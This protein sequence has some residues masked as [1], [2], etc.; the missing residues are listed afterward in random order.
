MAHLVGPFKRSSATA[1]PRHS[2]A[3]SSTGIRYVRFNHTTRKLAPLTTTAPH[4]SPQAGSASE[5][6]AGQRVRIRATRFSGDAKS[7]F[8][9]T[10]RNAYFY[11]VAN[12]KGRGGRGNADTWGILYDGEDDEAVYC[13]YSHLE[14]GS[15]REGTR[16]DCS[17]AIVILATCR[18]QCRRPPRD[19]PPLSVLYASP[20]RP[21]LLRRP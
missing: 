4:C 20:L 18:G 13:H 6:S 3:P 7:S 2:N 21:P 9:P 12:Q 19:M 5:I 14:I 17:V 1:T 10:W 8:G 16:M 11:G 15:P